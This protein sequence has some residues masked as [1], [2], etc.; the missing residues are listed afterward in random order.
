M[1][2]MSFSKKLLIIQS[3]NSKKYKDKKILIIERV[4]FIIASDTKFKVILFEV[5]NI[6]CILSI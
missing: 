1:Y 6:Y 3:N 2:T 4:N 5:H